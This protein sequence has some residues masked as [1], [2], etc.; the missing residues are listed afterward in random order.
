MRLLARRV[1]AIGAPRHDE[2][3]S[4]QFWARRLRPDASPLCRLLTFRAVRRVFAAVF[5]VYVR[6][7]RLICRLVS[8]NERK[9]LAAARTLTKRQLPRRR[10][11]RRRRHA[12]RHAPST[13]IAPTSL[14]LARCHRRCE[15]RAPARVA[16]T[17]ERAVVSRVRPEN[18]LRRRRHD[19]GHLERGLVWRVVRQSPTFGVIR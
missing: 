9:T 1:R 12:R 16:R 13:A 14:A 7:R 3:Q 19:L 4:A 10:R 11:R 2:P 18:E 15:R 6:Q 5:T 8:R 17:I